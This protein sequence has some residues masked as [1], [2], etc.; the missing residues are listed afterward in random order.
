M[1]EDDLEPL[2]TQCPNCDTSFRVSESQ[3]QIAQGRVRCGA[4]LGVFDGT[5]HLSQD[6]EE[7]AHEDEAADVDALLEELDEISDHDNAQVSS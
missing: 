6:G 1:A 4:C 5:A 2:V 7:L 3:L